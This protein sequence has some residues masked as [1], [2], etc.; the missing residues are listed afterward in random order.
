M[1][2]IKDVAKL[3]GVSISTVSLAMNYP[4]RVSELT[5][6]LIFEAVKA[7]KYTPFLKGRPVTGHNSVALISGE[8]SGPF[9][10]EVI[11]G[12]SETL[13]MNHLEMVMLTGTSSSRRNFYNALENPAFCGIILTQLA[14]LTRDDLE[15]AREKGIAIVLCHSGI[16]MRGIW[17]RQ[18]GQ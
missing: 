10:Y 16:T 2:S 15:K 17:H 4:E 6:K 8:I 13:S 9:Y 11:R 7:C 18:C 5:K 12:I 3:A 1:S 14:G